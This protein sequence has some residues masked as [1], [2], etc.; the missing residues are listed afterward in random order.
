ML[1]SWHSFAGYF[2]TVTKNDNPAYSVG[3]NSRCM[4]VSSMTATD[5][6]GWNI[7]VSSL[8][9][10][11]IVFRTNTT[12][13]YVT[14]GTIGTCGIN[15]VAVALPAFDIGVSDPSISG[16]GVSSTDTTSPIAVTATVVQ[17]EIAFLDPEQAVGNSVQWFGF[18]AILWAL[19]WGGRRVIDLFTHST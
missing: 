8:T 1:F 18:T 9:A 4:L 10:T 3:R 16:N 7:S 2:L 5:I 14:Q 19:A 6:A 17:P 15:P 11:S 13:F 12:P